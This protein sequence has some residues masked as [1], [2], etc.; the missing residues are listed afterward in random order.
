MFPGYPLVPVWWGFVLLLILLSASEA[1]SLGLAGILSV[2][3]ISVSSYFWTSILV[4][5]KRPG[6]RLAFRSTLSS[7]CCLGPVCRSSLT[8]DHWCQGLES[9]LIPF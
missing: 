1:V 9:V 8:P 7:C 6:N 4:L 3:G 5:V 2:A